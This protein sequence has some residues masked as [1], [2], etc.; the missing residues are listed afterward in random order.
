MNPDLPP[1]K[2]MISYKKKQMDLSDYTDTVEP[3]PGSDKDLYR[4]GVDEL[5]QLCDSKFYLE[6][7]NPRN[8]PI[9]GKD[10]AE[11][12][13]NLRKRNEEVSRARQDAYARY[14]KD[15]TFMLG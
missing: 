4:K 14:K 10:L 15:H 11:K 9:K 12:M 6:S 1:I 8:N 5:T 2:E 3:T 13:E 7:L